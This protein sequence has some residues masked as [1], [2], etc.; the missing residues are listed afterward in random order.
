MI[1]TNDIITS[2]LANKVS[3]INKKTKWRRFV[4][5]S[6][7]TGSPGQNEAISFIV[8]IST[9]SHN[10]LAEVTYK[11]I[12]KSFNFSTIFVGPFLASQTMHPALSE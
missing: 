9:N 10:A 6:I 7:T 2:K 3:R 4:D 11:V 12:S 1:F 5:F 8:T